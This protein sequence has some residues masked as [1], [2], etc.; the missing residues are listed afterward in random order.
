MPEVDNVPEQTLAAVTMASMCP[1]SNQL[2]TGS[3][4]LTRF[5]NTNKPSTAKNFL[6]EG[7]NKTILVGREGL[8][9]PT[10]SV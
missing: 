3:N 8:E 1:D 5:L 4:R 2:V 10:P 7:L 9:P 6:V